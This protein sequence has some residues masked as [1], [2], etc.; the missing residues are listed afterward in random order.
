MI[1]SE[2]DLDRYLLF[3]LNSEIYATPLMGVREVV[4]MHKP[5]QIPHTV[6]SFIGVINIRGEIVGVLDLRLRLGYEAKRTPGESMMVFDTGGG[7]IAA[8][9]DSMEGVMKIPS[10]AIDSK[11][12]IE[13]RLPLDFLM[14]VARLKDR[15][16]T[17]IDLGKVLHREEVR[18]LT[19][20]VQKTA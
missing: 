7:A 2:L 8:I 9:V 13:S 1:D 5:K 4:E 3:T 20:A 15:L 18:T 17:V 11:P 14:G 16:V 12:S 6:P 19:L 10:E